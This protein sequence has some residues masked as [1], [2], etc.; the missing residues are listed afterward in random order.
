MFDILLWTGAGLW[1]LFFV[2]LMVN[3]LMAHDLSKQ[4]WQEPDKWPFVSIV[5]PARNEEKN[6]EHAVT[7]FCQQYYPYF[8]VIVVDDGSTDS[9]P[10]ILKNL[11]TQFPQLKV[12]PGRELPAGWLGKPNALETGKQHAQGEWL[13]FVDADVIYDP[14]L[15]R[16][17]MAYVLKEK[18]AMLFLPPRFLTKGFL[19]PAIMSSLYF[20]ATTMIPVFLV[21]RTKCQYFAGG[22]GVFNLV[23]RDALDKC[24]A[25]DCLKDA[26]VDDVGLGFKVKGAGFMM[27]AALAGPLIK[28]RMYQGAKDTIQGFTKNMYPSIRKMPW[29]MLVPFIG[30]TVISFLPYVGFVD[31]LIHSQINV[32]ATIS[33]VLMH[34]IFLGIALTFKQPFRIMFLNPVRELAWWWIIVR[35]FFVY[36]KKGILW[37]GR[38]YH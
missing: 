6:I 18:S 17:A 22:G 9:T 31:G 23:R 36:H 25:F 1:V 13:L 30:G 8:E 5:V 16:R 11:Q 2:Q 21:T 15:L 27:S 38:E 19:E 28:I 14:G 35:S 33:L 24:Q 34:L 4:S 3:W 32:P 26:V 29:L 10:E 20:V 7:S 12:I 37:R